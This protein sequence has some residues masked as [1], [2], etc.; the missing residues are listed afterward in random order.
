M[1]LMGWDDA[2]DLGGDDVLGGHFPIKLM[3]HLVNQT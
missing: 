1:G 2:R 3:V